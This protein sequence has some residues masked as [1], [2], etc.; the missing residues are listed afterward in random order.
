MKKALF[1]IVSSVLILRCIAPPEHHDVTPKITDILI[2]GIP[3]SETATL[4]AG[5]ILEITP[6]VDNPSQAALSFS[7]DPIPAGAVFTGSTGML[8]WVPVQGGEYSFTVTVFLAAYPD[9]TDSRNA[10]V[11]VWSL[12]TIQDI[13]VNGVSFTQSGYLFAGDLLT[14]YPRV[15]NPSQA[16]LSFSVE[17]VPAGGVFDST[18]G[19]LSWTPSLAQTGG[20]NFSCSVF[21]VTRPD[22]RN[23]KSASLTLWTPVSLSIA[24]LDA[25]ILVGL[26]RPF[27]ATVSGGPTTA[28][29]WMV[30][31]IPG[32]NSTVGTISPDGLYTA[33]AGHPV[34][35]LVYVQVASVADPRK[36]ATAHLTVLTL[37][38][39][40]PYLGTFDIVMSSTPPSV[41]IIPVETDGQISLKEMAALTVTGTLM[42]V[43]ITVANNTF[44]EISG[45]NMTPVSLSDAGA[46][47]V[48][49]DNGNSLGNWFWSFFDI[50]AGGPSGGKTLSLQ[51]PGAGVTAR[52]RLYAD[53]PELYSVQSDCQTGKVTGLGR[54][55]GSDP[56]SGNRATV[57]QNIRV[58]GRLIQDDHVENWAD[59]TV[60]ARLGGGVTQGYVAVTKAGQPTNRKAV[61]S[62]GICRNRIYVTNFIGNSISVFDSAT[63][64]QI[65]GSPFTIGPPASRNCTLD[66]IMAP[67]VAVVDPEF[68][69]LYTVAFYAGAVHALDLTSPTLTPI[70]GSPFSTGS[71]TSTFPAGMAL[72]PLAHRLYV[73]NFSASTLAVFDTVT[74]THIPGSPFSTPGT[75]G[76]MA[77]DPVAHRLYITHFFPT[78]N[79]GIP[80]TGSGLSWCEVQ[81]NTFSVWDTT[82]MTYVTVTTLPG[83]IGLALDQDNHRLFVGH[84]GTVCTPDLGFTW[85]VGPS[86]I[87]V[88][89]TP[90]LAKTGSMSAGANPE[91]MTFDP[92]T[93][94][95]YV[96]T[97]GNTVLSGVTTGCIQAVYN[98][99]SSLWVYNTDTLS[100]IP[101]SPFATGIQP[102]GIGYDPNLTLLAVANYG[103]NT[104]TVYTTT[105]MT[106]RAGS[107]FAT[108]GTG[109]VG[110]V[111]VEPGH[112]PL[113]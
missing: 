84:V 83:P 99:G 77:V 38:L 25:Q 40:R 46:V 16:A 108:G 69:R 1:G 103:S 29:R 63:M 35:S 21:A 18:S 5:D 59:T 66:G 100:P 56:G 85:N 6:R 75:P 11:T 22:S 55:L 78:V 36:T 27:T 82:T 58:R 26:S 113:R 52:V 76:D 70:P 71:D 72:D 97:F 93:R 94:R 80:F 12:P 62:T 24:P 109:P 48:N 41:K 57:S 106:Q 68:S 98:G 87:E 43:P 101:G 67:S 32:G 79:G 44:T 4:F 65:P 47:V 110:V 92:E 91:L 104:L 73:G 13:L 54:N 10:S 3:V 89:T 8:S 30:N 95:L 2:N 19:T 15:D 88:F 39:A 31:G 61:I 112:F 23:S 96:S 34:P 42:S 81:Q 9:L 90:T 45:V 53:N 86:G 14:I 50:P 51:T 111:A 105:T 60:T 33:P 74:M 17:T 37:P 107:P 64:T 49:P 102:L 20:Y 7:I 28:V